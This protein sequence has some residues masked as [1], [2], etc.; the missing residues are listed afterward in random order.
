MLTDILLTG[1]AI[2]VLLGTLIFFHEFGHFTMAKL[3]KMKV[4][5]FAF[6]FG[7]KWIRLFK[8]GDTEYTIHPVPLGG[9]V[10]LAGM[11]PGEEHVA[12]GFMEKPWYSRF[13]VY[14]AGPAM[15]FVL[16]YLVFCMLGLT[17]GLPITGDMTNKVDVVMPGSAADK[18]GLNSGDTIVSINGKKISSGKQMLETVHSNSFKPL[19][20]VVERDGRRFTAKAVP[21]P[22]QLVLNKLGLVVDLPPMSKTANSISKVKA[23][24]PAAKVGFRVGDVISHIGGRRISSAYD[25]YSAVQTEVDRP[26][27]FEIEREGK[28]AV[29]VATLLPGEINPKEV[30]GLIGF[31]PKQRLERVGL[32]KSIAFGN[33]ATVTFVVTT[34][35][36]L[37]SR[38]V[39]DA[40]G[41]PIA[42][43]DATLNSV[44]RGLY[45]YLQLVGILSLSL[46]IVNIIPIPVVDGGQ[47]LLLL[48]EFV[49]GRRLSQRTVEMSQ[50]IGWT[51]IAILF[52]LIMYL[53]LTRLA[54][55]K[56][57]R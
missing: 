34:V 28:P 38:E 20:L 3:L 54:T 29:I 36:V 7:P 49:R 23:G 44:R 12:G 16:A 9:F 41:G 30:N 11:E 25:L 2:I 4:D 17:V 46:A 47:M 21:Q 57:F 50:R 52:A 31:V 6:G 19:T 56:L 32:R 1:P 39:K 42:I 24:S 48:V 13:L 53:D 10:K 33:D 18:L 8:L 35:K 22:A 55:N 27:R 5:E 37:F 14:F 45:G 43:A 51:M 15:S 40:V 26:L